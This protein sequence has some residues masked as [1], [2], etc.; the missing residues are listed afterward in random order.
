MRILEN[1]IMNREE[2]GKVERS[3]WRGVR[4]EIEVQKLSGEIRVW[5][6]IDVK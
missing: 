2:R 3:N 4:I 5:S 6:M 1:I